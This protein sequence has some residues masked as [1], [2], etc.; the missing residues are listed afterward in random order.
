MPP[1]VYPEYRNPYVANILD[2]MTQAGA[3]QAAG[4]RQAGEAIGQGQRQAGDIY[5]QFLTGIG[6]IPQQMA[7]QQY[8]SAQIANMQQEMALRQ[9]E[10]TRIQQQQA[11]VQAAGQAIQ[12]MTYVDKDGVRRVDRSRLKSAVPPGAESIVEDEISKIDDASDRRQ[13]ALLAKQKADRD[14]FAANNAAFGHIMAGVVRSGL[15]PQTLAAGRQMYNELTNNAPEPGQFTQLADGLSQGTTTSDALLGYLKTNPNFTNAQVEWE[16][17]HPVVKL[18]EKET[19]LQP[20]EIPGEPPKVLYRAPAAAP[21]NP[22]EAYVLAAPGKILGRPDAKWSDLTAAQQDAAITQFRLT[23]PEYVAN[24]ANLRLASAQDQQ[25]RLQAQAQNFQ[26]RR[27]FSEDIRK[28]VMDPYEKVQSAHNQLQTMTSSIRNN[29]NTVAAGQLATG[30]VFSNLAASGITS[31]L[32]IAAFKGA[33]NPGSVS[34]RLQSWW[35]KATQGTKTDPRILDDTD[36]FNN[37]TLNQAYKE[38]RQ[39]INSRARLLGMPTINAD[40]FVTP[41]PGIWVTSPSGKDVQGP[42]PSQAAADAFVRDATS[43]GKWK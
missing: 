17:E 5:G 14:L 9:A 38:A 41:P 33:E 42:F 6:Q 31:R 8:R 21:T 11:N 40:Q 32:P 20:S 2:L 18:G 1:F 34:D 24:Q 3:A 27:E 29:N 39:R 13:T 28:D 7:A 15:T 30:T 16:K 43:R 22:F 37:A 26:Q 19:L 36:T 10:A 4:V 35:N 23:T 25:N 12:E